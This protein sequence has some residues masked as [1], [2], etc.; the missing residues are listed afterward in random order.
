MEC[1]CTQ[2]IQCHCAGSGSRYGYGYE[3]K[4]IR[5]VPLSPIHLL[6]GSLRQ[7]HLKPVSQP[8]QALG[9]PPS[10]LL[11]SASEVHLR[12]GRGGRLLYS[13]SEVHLRDGRGGRL[14]FLLN[15]E[16]CTSAMD[17]SLKGALFIITHLF[18]FP[19]SRS[20]VTLFWL[21]L[22]PG[23]TW[24]VSDVDDEDQERV[25]RQ[26]VRDR[27]I[28]AYSKVNSQRR[29]LNCPNRRLFAHMH[30][31]LH[32]SSMPSSG[33]CSVHNCAGSVVCVA[34]G[35]DPL[36]LC[37]EVGRLQVW[38][39]GTREEGPSVVGPRHQGGERAWAGTVE[40]VGRLI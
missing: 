36:R 12:D 20:A 16:G 32:T 34:P 26:A 13:A 22:D 14:I 24:Q 31:H 7:G 15:G 28:F 18:V 10:G 17:R 19:H 40:C 8:P 2:R 39:L 30:H 37:T 27:S 35:Q 25:W 5:R 4:C 33:C 21:K 29:L 38:G 9:L 11:H 1:Q 3:T 23:M 6:A